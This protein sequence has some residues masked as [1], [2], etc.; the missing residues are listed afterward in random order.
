MTCICYNPIQIAQR[1]YE[2]IRKR[3]AI[4]QNTI[5]AYMTYTKRIN[6]NCR[7]IAKRNIFELSIHSNRYHAKNSTAHK[8][9][10]KL[11]W[12]KNDSDMFLLEAQ[13]MTKKIPLQ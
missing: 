7:V 5:L 1:K 9:I 13:K 8:K 3:Y 12:T 2:I 10:K 6:E 11:S 4:I